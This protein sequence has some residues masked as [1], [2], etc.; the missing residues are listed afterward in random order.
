MANMVNI[1]CY[2]CERSR[3]EIEW[4]EMSN[5]GECVFPNLIECEIE[6]GEMSV[7]EVSEFS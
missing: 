1:R 7:T 6:W 2:G 5:L 3:S 4:G